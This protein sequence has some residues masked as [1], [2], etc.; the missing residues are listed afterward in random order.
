MLKQITHLNMRYTTIYLTFTRIK[1]FFSPKN[2]F[3]TN[4]IRDTIKRTDLRMCCY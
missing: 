4:V 3:S 2:D 1:D